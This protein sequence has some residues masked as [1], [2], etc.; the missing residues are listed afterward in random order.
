MIARCA[1][2]IRSISAASWPIS[3]S[4]PLGSASSARSLSRSRSSGGITSCRKTRASW[5]TCGRCGARR[6]AK[7]SSAAIGAGSRAAEQAGGDLAIDVDERF[8]PLAVGFGGQL[9]RLVEYEQSEIADVLTGFGRKRIVGGRHRGKQY[10]PESA[11]V[12]Q[13]VVISVAL[14]AVPFLDDGLQLRGGL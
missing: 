3:K 13:C 2:S 12:G 9:D 4:L 7:R 1:G 11:I 5:I 10:H 8:D 14:L 6:I